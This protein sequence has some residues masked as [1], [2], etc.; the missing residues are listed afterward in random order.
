MN[1]S[2]IGLMAVVALSVSNLAFAYGPYPNHPELD[3]ANNDLNSALNSLAQANN[4]NDPADPFGG[5]REAAVNVLQNQ[6][7]YQINESVNYAN[8]YPS[9][10][11]CQP[12][13]ANINPNPYPRHP[14]LSQADVLLQ[15]AVLSLRNACNGPN[16]FGGYRD[17]A[18]ASVQQAEN[19][20]AAAVQWANNH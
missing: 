6:A 8:T 14:N 3:A 11:Y 16:A 19:D 7:L 5:Y 17:Q 2:V 12:Q 10:G 18:I 1:K 9:S 20:I 15:Q 4:P 13:Y